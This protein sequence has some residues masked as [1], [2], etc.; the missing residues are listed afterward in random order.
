[1]K[2]GEIILITLLV[3]TGFLMAD[4]LVDHLMLQGVFQRFV[5][6]IGFQAQFFI[7]IYLFFDLRDNSRRLQRLERRFAREHRLRVKDRA[8]WKKWKIW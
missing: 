2:P 5:M 3:I 7:L 1:M 8:V 4:F 6:R